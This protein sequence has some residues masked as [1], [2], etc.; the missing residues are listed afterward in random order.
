MSEKNKILEKKSEKRGPF[1]YSLPP[2]KYECHSHI[3]PFDKKEWHS[4]FTPPSLPI[5]GV[6]LRS[7]AQ[8]SAA[9]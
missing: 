3:A 9:L 5:L 2:Q 8:K 6:A 4:S 7:S 1:I